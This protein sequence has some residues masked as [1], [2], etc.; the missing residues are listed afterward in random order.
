MENYSTAIYSACVVDLSKQPSLGFESRQ[1]FDIPP[2]QI[3]VT[4]HRAPRACCSCH[5]KYTLG[6]LPAEAPINVEY[7]P[8]LCTIA[9][10]CQ[11]YQLLSDFLGQPVSEGTI[12]SMKPAA[13][14]MALKNKW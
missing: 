2:I 7:S 6:H 12:C 1:V 4:K 9:R 3:K 5:G 11:Y 8:N 10:Y 14:Y 13:S